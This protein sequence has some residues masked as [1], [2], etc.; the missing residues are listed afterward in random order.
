MF[1]FLYIVGPAAITYLMIHH[2]LNKDTI[3]YFTGVLEL[4]SYAAL[5]AA[6][7][8]L[9]LSPFKKVVIVKIA[10]GIKDIQYGGT[11]FIFS[12]VVGVIVGIVISIL[13]KY[14]AFSIEI[15]L[16]NKEE[17]FVNLS[18]DEQENQADV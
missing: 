12:L 14:F 13:K 10:S 8:T 3:P 2:I 16:Q 6:I 15:E 5:D 4:I 7:T 11:A 18:V 1:Q 17:A 9:L